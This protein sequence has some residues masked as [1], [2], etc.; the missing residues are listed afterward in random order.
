MT[1]SEFFSL[2]HPIIG[3]KS[4]THQFA[5]TLFDLIL[6]EDGEGVLDDYSD[7]SFK[8][9]ANG[10]TGISR[11]AKAV[12][13]YL[14]T[15]NFESYLEKYI[16]SAGTRLCDVFRP[17][18]S[19]ISVKNVIEKISDLFVTII[20]EAATTKKGASAKTNIE[21]KRTP[22]SVDISPIDAESKVLKTI[23]HMP[24]DQRGAALEEVLNYGRK[25]APETNS[26]ATASAVSVTQNGENNYNVN[27]QSGGTVNFNITHSNVR[28]ANSAETMMAI[29]SFSS[30]YYQLLVTCDDTIFENNMLEMPVGRALTKYGVPDEIFQRCSTLSREGIAELKTF[31][32]IICVEN[33]QMK[34]ITDQS[35]MALFAYLRKIQKVGKSIKIVFEPLAV[36]QQ[37]KL[38]DK[39]NAVFFD[40]NMECAITDL[41]RSEWTVHRT[42]VF[43]A[44]DEAGIT[45]I[46]RPQ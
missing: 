24:E 34:G 5:R 13:P 45:G 8:A 20:E 23:L 43:E 19:D 21:S 27:N 18:I 14:D 3:G 1:F 46:P 31:P 12:R 4:S 41:N 44:F 29:Q 9:Y 6:S 30:E 37:L 22:S 10:N 42:N 38:C 17:Y 2:L 26:G 16:D 39:R 15:Y 40:L 11:V 7:D 35:Q 33:T 25:K 28:P 36:F 32:A